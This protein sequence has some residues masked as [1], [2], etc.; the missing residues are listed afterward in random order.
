MN[1]RSEPEAEHEPGSIMQSLTSFSIA[2]GAIFLAYAFGMAIIPGAVLSR[3]PPTPGTV[4]LSTQAQRGRDV[5]VGEGCTY[6]HTQQ[7]RPLA[8]DRVWGRPSL[9]GDFAFAKPELLGTERTGPDLANVG[10]RQADLWNEIHL[11]QP[12]SL[13]SQSIMPS[14]RW[15]FVTKTKTDPGDVV[16]PVPSAFAPPGQTVVATP[17]LLALVAYLRELKQAPLAAV[18]R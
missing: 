7:V 17:D 2:V 15:L 6:C 10:A 1:G 3:T 5:Y 4:A 8:Q 16:V 13:V 18:T 12:R 9:A 11:Y 14:Y